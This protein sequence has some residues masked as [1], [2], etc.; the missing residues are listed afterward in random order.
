MKRKKEGILVRDKIIR[1]N[2]E[3]KKNGFKKED[4]GVER[5]ACRWKTTKSSWKEG[6]IT[7]KKLGGGNKRKKIIRKSEK[8]NGSEI[9]FI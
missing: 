4:N 3:K 2:N 1:E 6:E 5:E 8:K 9:H 7:K